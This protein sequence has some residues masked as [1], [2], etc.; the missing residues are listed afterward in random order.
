VARLFSRKPVGRML[1]IKCGAHD[2]AVN[3]PSGSPP[4]ASHN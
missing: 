2:G 4:E 3:V 1:E